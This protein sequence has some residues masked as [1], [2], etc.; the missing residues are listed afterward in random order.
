MHQVDEVREALDREFPGYAGRSGDWEGVLARVQ[1]SAPEPRR[2]RRRSPL[3][4]LAAAVVALAASALLW[5]GGDGSDRVLERARA[6]VTAEPVIHLV[7]GPEPAALTEIRLET[8]ERRALV[9]RHEQ[10]FDPERGLHDV[11]TVGGGVQGD[12]LYPA[13][14]YPELDQQFLGLASAYRK[15][16]ESGHASVRGKG[17]VDG[18][19]VHW[20]AFHVRYPSAGIPLYDA[21]HEVAV[22][23]ETFEPRLWRSTQHH[24][25]LG[26]PGKVTKLELEIELWETLPAGSG[27][28]TAA[29]VANADPDDGWQGLSKVGAKTPEE[30][31]SVLSPR[32]LWLGAE[33]QSLRLAGMYEI[34]AERGQVGGPIE[35]TPALEACY[36]AR[37]NETSCAA[38]RD[39]RFVSIAQA[40]APHPMLGWTEVR[41]PA[42]GTMVVPDRGSPPYAQGFARKGGVYAVITASDEELL[43]AAAR[44]LEPIP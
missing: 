34:S 31:R 21:D 20:I 8:G 17:T 43:L 18:R 25:E 11:Y 13:G 4:A 9:G 39:G 36:G 7:L 40:N 2:P 19:K 42:E 26:I 22:D 35:R 44:A 3:V 1:A 32:A 23:A 33:F 30:A 41:E 29:T 37:L 15:A 27:D 28:F 24:Q 16:L 6:V 12:V 5:P 14:S 10:W 38:P